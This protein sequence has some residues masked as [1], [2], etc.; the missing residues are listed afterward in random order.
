MLG[1]TPGLRLDPEIPVSA[2]FISFFRRSHLMQS[3]QDGDPKGS[4]QSSAETN[5][6]MMFQ[7][8]SKARA[9]NGPQQTQNLHSAEIRKQN[10]G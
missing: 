5:V 9:V 1:P 3:T 8:A 4:G 2:L 10:C 6:L 7:E